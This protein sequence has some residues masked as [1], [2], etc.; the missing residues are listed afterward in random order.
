[1]VK[2]DGCIK[3]DLSAREVQ[4]VL[5]IAKGKTNTEIADILFISI[6]TVKTHTKHIFEKLSVKNRTEAIMKSFSEGIL[7]R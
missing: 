7:V 6:N 4:V 3:H 1:M 2:I 5:L